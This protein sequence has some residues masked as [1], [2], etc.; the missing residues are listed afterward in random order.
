MELADN[1]CKENDGWHKKP[2][3]ASRTERRNARASLENISRKLNR[4]LVQ[5]GAVRQGLW[6]G[7]G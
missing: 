2:G 1:R 7:F 4:I 3:G 6:V 5:A